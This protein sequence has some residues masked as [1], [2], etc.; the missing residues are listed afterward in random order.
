VVVS[1][2]DYTAQVESPVPLDGLQETQQVFAFT[3]SEALADRDLNGDGDLDDPVLTIRDRETGELEPI[4]LAGSDGRA[5]TRLHQDPFT[6]PAVAT[7]GDVVA[8]LEAEPNQGAADAN[9][10][11][12]IFE[13][14]LRAFRLGAG[15]VVELTGA[16]P[17][18]AEADPVLNG[19]SA[20]LSNG[21]LFFR[22]REAAEAQQGIWAVSMDPSGDD[23]S[24]SH[25]VLSRNGRF[26]AFDSFATSLVPSDTNDTRDVFVHDRATGQTTRVN[27]SSSGAQANDISYLDSMSLDGRFVSFT[28]N[29]SNLVPGDTN[30]EDVFLHDR[31]TGD[32]MRVS[33]SSAG[34][35]GNGASS[36]SSVSADGQLVTFGSLASNLVAGDTNDVG[37]VFVR[38]LSA[39][40]TTFASTS[41][42]GVLGNGQSRINLG[43]S[44][45]PDG[46]RVVFSSLA[47]NLAGSSS[48]PAGLF[49]RAVDTGLVS[50]LGDASNLED[51]ALSPDGRFVVFSGF[52]EATSCN[53]LVC[54][55]LSGSTTGECLTSE[56]ERLNGR[57]AA[58][59][60]AA[61]F[62]TFLASPGDELQSNAYLRDRITHHTANVSVAS[63]GAP[64]NDST[65]DASVS[66]DGAF[67]SFSSVA[68]NLVAGDTNGRSDVFVRGPDASDLAADRSQDG[69]LDDVVL[70]VLDTAALTPGAVV[71]LCPADAVA[72]AAGRAA[73]LRPEAA[74]ASAAA[75]CTQPLADLNGDG[76]ELDRIVQLYTGAAV[77]NLEVA[78]TDV[79]LSESF[80]AA[81]VSEA[82]ESGTN[83]NGD[84]DA[85][86]TVLAVNPAA[87]ASAAMWTN[88]GQAA[89]ALAIVGS[90]VAFATPEAAQGVD[91]DGDG[92]TLDRV[93]QLYDAGSAALSNTGQAIDEFVL[94]DAI[95]AFRTPESAQG[96]TDLNG[97]GD[98]AD[99]VLQVRDLAS[100]QTLSSGLAAVRCELEACD[101]R[102]P[103]RVAGSTVTFLVLE[104]QQGGQDLD[105]DGDGGDLILHVMSTAA[106]AA[107][108]PAAPPLAFAALSSPAPTAATWP[109]ASASA[110]VCTTTGQACASDVECA[111]GACFTPPGTCDLDLGTPCGGSGDEPCGAGQYCSTEGTCHALS[112]PCKT[113]GDC[114]A[115]AICT[116]TDQ[117]IQR[118]LAPI[119]TASADA[120][121]GAQVLPS[122]GVC[123]ENTA[124]ACASSADCEAGTFC[125][126]GLCRREHGACDTSADCPIGTCNQD[127]T[128]ATAADADAD[129]LADPIDDCPGVSNPDQ[130]D[131]DGD[132]LGDACDAF[133]CGD[134]V[135]DGAPGAAGA[136]ECDDGNQS[137]GDGCSAACRREA[138][139]CADGFDND[140]DGLVDYGTG[141][142]K[143]PGCSSMAAAARENPQCSN[144]VD[145][146]FDGQVDYPA[147]TKCQNVKDNDELNNPAPP[148]PGCGIGGELVLVFAL[149]HLGARADR[150][151][152]EP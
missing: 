53:L 68:S 60:E 15:G 88:V 65:Q 64:P 101:P 107:P 129:G 152:R 2:S 132:A 100:G 22:T 114:T 20:V 23:Q 104:A 17:I 120:A 87:S 70:R 19:R 10:N 133:E 118:L 72:V 54:D 92:D 121:A 18:T 131:A 82:A 66:A 142:G 135:R 126:D 13:S 84:G 106:T 1:E 21:L 47:T 42:S 124:V 86:D 123:R 115:S 91:L 76:D 122:A 46:R 71:D 35:E 62:E 40:S 146:D 6:Y 102:V 45:S 141:A 7:E 143:D 4:G 108:P 48:W 119:A 96:G 12:R 24:L 34:I 148:A 32:T 128:T 85:L 33:V 95:V 39:G 94:G 97:D 9:G 130:A 117:Q 59:S 112:D 25:S 28:S 56:G 151:R 57:Y 14:V 11:G 99:S 109:L 134:G 89:D 63:D 44:L 136:E 150:R 3:T 26:I 29:A 50:R 8:F 93:L 90:V 36:Y 55:A 27:V 127:L 144:G 38:D 79:A 73:F 52:S 30:G 51:Q 103:Y 139:E 78:A 77:V 105:G 125:G 98:T 61:R 75:S 145:D 37:D 83:L 49:S 43:A 69:A 67:V 111:G 116:D 137:A 74:G 138:T 58:L 41:S 149:L 31:Q 81:L 5:A 110:G 113:D 80:V 147:D 140:G 16:A